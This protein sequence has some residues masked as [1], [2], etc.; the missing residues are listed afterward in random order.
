MPFMPKPDHV[1]FAARA[2][3]EVIARHELTIR[4]TNRRF[5]PADEWIL[6]EGGEPQA[7]AGDSVLQLQLL[8]PT[9]TVKTTPAVAAG[10][11]DR[12]WTMFDFVKLLEV[13]EEL[14]GG[15]LKDY[16]MAASKRR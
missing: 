11:T 1:E 3:A 2:A 4:M 15:R 10:L 7:H 9:M 12:V 8:P 16:K 6:K 14:I 5:T 13:H